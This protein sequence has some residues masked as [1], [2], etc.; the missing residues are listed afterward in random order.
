M[1]QEQQ[2]VTESAVTQLAAGVMSVEERIGRLEAEAGRVAPALSDLEVRVQGIGGTAQSITDTMAKVEEAMVNMLTQITGTNVDLS[3]SRRNIVAKSYLP[4]VDH[5]LFG[6][7][8][9]QQG[10]VVPTQS[11]T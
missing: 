10:K 2:N 8:R 4:K 5:N 1:T 7:D 3:K 6:E 11:W 9:L